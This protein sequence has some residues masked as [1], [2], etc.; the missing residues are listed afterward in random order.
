MVGA[1]L[2]PTC[3]TGRKI[4]PTP[5]NRT[6][7]IIPVLIKD[8]EGSAKMSGHGEYPEESVSV[9][10]HWIKLHSLEFVDRPTRPT[11]N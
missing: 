9:H 2:H 1:T 10:S 7:I 11:Y 3:A 5:G 8:G 6:W 4:V